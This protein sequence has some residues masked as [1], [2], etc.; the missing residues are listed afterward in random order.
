MVLRSAAPVAPETL[1]RIEFQD[2]TLIGRIDSC[3]PDVS[4]YLV[5][6]E[7]VHAIPSLSDLGRLVLA[8]IQEHN[9][10]AAVVIPA[11]DNVV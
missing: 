10:P 8:V 2:G 11:P 1:V 7:I 3:R 9:S 4:G 5:L 6:A